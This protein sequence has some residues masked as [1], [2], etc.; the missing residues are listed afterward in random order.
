MWLLLSSLLLVLHVT[1]QGYETLQKIYEALQTRMACRTHILNLSSHFYSI[2]PHHSRL[3]VIDTMLKLGKKVA[4]MESVCENVRG[5]SA[6][7]VAALCRQRNY[8]D[9]CYDLLGCDLEPLVEA[10]SDEFAYVKAYL[11]GSSCCGWKDGTLQLLS[12]FRVSKPDERARFEPY[13]AF[14]NRRVRLRLR[15]RLCEHA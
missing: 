11:K 3:D 7:E 14:P 8:L 5:M 6:M 1:S 15:L 2:I 12:V 10:S 13:R 9:E 4:M